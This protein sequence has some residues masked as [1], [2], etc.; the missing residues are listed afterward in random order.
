MTGALGIHGQVSSLEAEGAYAIKNDI[1]VVMNGFID[2]EKNNQY[3]LEAGAGKFGKLDDNITYEAFGGIGYGH[4]IF[5]DE[6]QTPYPSNITRT[7]RILKIYFQP[8]ISYNYSLLF[9]SLSM[10]LSGLNY[11]KLNPELNEPGFYNNLYPFFE[12]AIT[13]GLRNNYFQVF[14]QYAYSFGDL[15]FNVA[16]HSISLGIQL[17]IHDITKQIVDLF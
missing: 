16:R 14:G 12:P 17:N 9:G 3:T 2:M 7:A 1:G 5:G 13:L 15:P 10:R 4:F 8:S 6:I 11:L